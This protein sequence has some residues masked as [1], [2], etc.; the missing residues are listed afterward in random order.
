M[1]RIQ[2]NIL[3]ILHTSVFA[4]IV[5]TITALFSCEDNEEN[6]QTTSQEVPIAFQTSMEGQAMV[7]RADSLYY[8][9]LDTTEFSLNEKIG[10]FAYYTGNDWYHEGF[11][12][13]FMYNQMVEQVEKTNEKKTWNYTPVKYWP[14]NANDKLTFTAYYPYNGTG[15]TLSP[16]T[17]KGL[18]TIFFHTQ[19]RTEEQI[20]L[21]V[22]D[23]LH[24][25][26]H[27]ARPDDGVDDP[28]NNIF[29]TVTAKVPLNFHHA[30][31]QIRFYIYVNIDPSSKWYGKLKLKLQLENVY[32]DGTLTF[33]FNKIGRYTFADMDDEGNYLTNAWSARDNV[34]TLYADDYYYKGV[35]WDSDNNKVDVNNSVIDIK[36]IFCVV[37][38][39]PTYPLLGKTEEPIL[40]IFATKEG[41]DPPEQVATATISNAYKPGTKW[42]WRGGWI[43]R[44]TLRLNL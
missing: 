25:C 24:D 9:G 34:G 27:I 29:R 26:R 22:S 11:V 2:H 5:L 44:Y 7:T 33:P 42:E 13:N 36:D 40:R 37:P 19:E 18:P 38:Q 17:K 30:L 43:Y 4:L 39:Q 12:P 35:R 21:L 3:N 8:H 6:G 10:V 41:S 23:L 32:K 14:N 1:N 20:D 15:I 28:V 16:N 31:A